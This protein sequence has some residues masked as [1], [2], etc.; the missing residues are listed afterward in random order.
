MLEWYRSTL[1]GLLTVNNREEATSLKD[2]YMECVPGK[3]TAL[4]I[5]K[6]LKLLLSFFVFYLH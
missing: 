3:V 5:L 6:A 2:K 4:E 1:S